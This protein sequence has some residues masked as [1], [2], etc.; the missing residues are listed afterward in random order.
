MLS[1]TQVSIAGQGIGLGRVSFGALDA[2]L[3]NPASLSGL[4][5]A[6]ASNQTIELSDGTTIPAKIALLRAAQASQDI[7]VLSAPT[8]LTTDNVE[9]EI[10]VGENVPFIASQATNGSQLDNLFTTVQREDVG[11]TLRITPQISEGDHVRL[12]IYEEVSAIVP[13]SPDVGSPTEVGPTTSVR[14]ART[15]VVVKDG[16]TVVVGGLISD[17]RITRQDSVPYLSDIPILGHLF[18]TDQKSTRKVNLLIFLTPHIVRDDT[19]IAVRSVHER[20]RFGD[21]L[22]QSNAPTKW[23]KA[24][25]RP[26][27]SP[28]STRT[29]H[30]VLLPASRGPQ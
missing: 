9:A 25:N 21:F 11:I 10:I 27:F 4:L 16:Q 1:R 19:E 17:D 12:E 6:A 8:I 7:N 13:T 5:F 28:L 22:T 29:Q 26:S 3:A 15:T 30:G 23:R 18:R 20:N 14:I 2:A 24:L